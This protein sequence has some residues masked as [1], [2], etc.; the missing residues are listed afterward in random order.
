MRSLLKLIMVYVFKV[1]SV[2]GE[3]VVFL[4]VDSHF[5]SFAAELKIQNILCCNNCVVSFVHIGI[6][7]KIPRVIIPR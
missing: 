7:N 3:T 2:V 5:S 4:A 6:H 1:H